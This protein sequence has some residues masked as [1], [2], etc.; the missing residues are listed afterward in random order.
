MK[1]RAYFNL[2]MK[3][4]RKREKRKKGARWRREGEAV[5]TLKLLN[6]VVAQPTH[7]F[8]YPKNARYNKGGGKI[9]VSVK[10]VEKRETRARNPLEGVLPREN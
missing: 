2:A 8:I 3:R 1:S 9:K 4:K 7:I 10:A 5:G 6:G